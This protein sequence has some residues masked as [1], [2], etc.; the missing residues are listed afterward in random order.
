[1]LSFLLACAGVDE[2]APD[3]VSTDED[4]PVAADPCIVRT[5]F[6]DQDDDGYGAGDG[7]DT[8]Q[9]PAGHVGNALDCDDADAFISPGALE[10]CDGIDNDCNGQVDGDDAY[11]ADW[12]YPDLDQDDFGD[13]DWGELRCPIDGWVEREGDCDDGDPSISPD[14]VEVLDS[15]DQDCDGVADDGLRYGS[16]V[17]GSFTISSDQELPGLSCEPVVF[18]DDAGLQVEDTA[19]FSVGDRLLLVEQQ[20]R[21]GDSATVGQLDWLTVGVIEEGLVVPL[22]PPVALYGVSADVHRLALY[23]VPQ[24]TDLTVEEGVTVT[25]SP[26]DGA[27]GGVLPVLATGVIAL[28][29]D[30]DM[31]SAGFSGGPPNTTWESTGVAGESWSGRGT[32]GNAANG[33]G[34]G[35]GGIGASACPDCESSGGGGGFGLDAADGQRSDPAWG[36]GGQGGVEYGNITLDEL[37]LGSGGGAGALDIDTEGGV[38]GGG[39]AGGGAIL[40]QAPAVLAVGALTVDGEAGEVACAG[41]EDWCFSGY[42]SEAGSGGGGSGGTI[43]IDTELLVV[44]AL[45]ARGGDGGDGGDGSISAGGDGAVG[46]IR[47]QAGTVNG[48]DVDSDAGQ[49]AL[50]GACV[51]DPGRVERPAD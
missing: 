4:R 20:A 15:I 41:T 17:D 26:W 43:W 24:L 3:S 29:G 5:W 47:V 34:G 39:G 25:A 7:V 32:A 12:W 38:G 1:M 30:L 42:D 51:P 35:G 27:C 23:R 14:A 10:E 37:N 18:L 31:T 6:A 19:A 36:D 44:T 50:N 49:D 28:D 9:R 16:G 40:I 22:D 8:C 11:G 21:V 33:G 48:A 2:P 45:H 13:P 46:R